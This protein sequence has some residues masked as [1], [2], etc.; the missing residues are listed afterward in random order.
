MEKRNYAACVKRDSSPALGS[1]NKCPPGSCTRNIINSQELSCKN[2]L[3]AIQIL[4][5]KEC[6]VNTLRL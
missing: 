3:A 2:V 4:G 1:G 6:D 5:M